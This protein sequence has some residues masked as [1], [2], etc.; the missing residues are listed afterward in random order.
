MTETRNG[1]AR[2]LNA[3]LAERHMTPLDLAKALK[4][5][6]T[7]VYSWTQGKAIPR[8]DKMDAI[9]RYLHIY[10]EELLRTGVPA[11]VLI[12]DR[13]RYTDFVI[14]DD[15]M[16]PRLLAGDI[17]IADKQKDVEDGK[18]ALVR[19]GGVLACR[20]LSLVKGGVL[21]SCMSGTIPPVF[22]AAGDP[23][24]LIL[25]PVIEARCTF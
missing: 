9:C 25:G 17:V 7:T 19:I 11:S 14:P 8:A 4:I 10:P 21:I 1:F 2:N 12:D 6:Q 16:S 24:L 18:P 20:T 22:F 3:L 5:A 23:D 13:K 15:L